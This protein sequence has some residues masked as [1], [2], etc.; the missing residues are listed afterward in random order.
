MSNSLQPHGLQHTRPPLS[1]TSSWSLLKLMPTESVMPS[2]HLILCRRLLLLGRGST[3]I[4]K[5]S[6]C[7][8]TPVELFKTLKDDAIKVLHSLC[9]EI[10]RTQKWPQDWKRSILIPIPK[11]GST[12]E[13]ANHWTVAV[14]T[15]TSKV[16]LKILRA[17]L[18]Q[19]AN[20]ELP[21]V[22]AGFRKERGT[23]N[24]IANIP[25]SQRKLGNFRKTSTSV[26]LTMLKL[27]TVWIIKNCGK[28]LERREY[29]TILPVS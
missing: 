7:Y 20:Q 1:N 22:Q 15:H 28:L 10:W 18:Q 16:M 25:G 29:P 21:D 6:G 26:S 2:N 14:I 27:L 13:C 9:Q 19:Y 23:R 8:G 24:Q 4:N 17:K 5:A 11:K 12:K 3:V